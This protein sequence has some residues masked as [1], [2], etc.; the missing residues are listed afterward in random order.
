MTKTRMTFSK[1][2]RLSSRKILSGLFE[3]G[4]VIIVSPF[5]L[6]WLQT[7]LPSSTPVQIAF[8][9]PVKN[10]RRAVDRNRI[11]RQIR[12]VYRKNKSSV[13]A[14]SESRKKQYALM[15]VFIGKVKPTFEEVESKLKLVL[16]RLEE[17][18][19]KHAE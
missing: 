16:H 17:D 6:L 2:E 8:S 13:Y 7:T 9:V 1:D 14:L 11:K 12:E 4:K 5:R 3:K 15:I 18:L 10:F 19:Q